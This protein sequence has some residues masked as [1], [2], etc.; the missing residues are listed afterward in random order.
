MNRPVGECVNPKCQSTIHI[1]DFFGKIKD[2]LDEWDN[3]KEDWKK[4]L[5]SELR[6]KIEHERSNR[7]TSNVQTKMIPSTTEV[8]ENVVYVW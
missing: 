1:A 4:D 6:Q 5:Q 3:N 2:I 8:D 7:T